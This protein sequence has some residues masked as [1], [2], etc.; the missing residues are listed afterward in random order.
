MGDAWVPLTS[1]T[2]LLHPQL[3]FPTVGFATMTAAPAATDSATTVG[4][5]ANMVSATRDQIASTAALVRPDR[6]VH[7]CL[8][9]HL[10]Y[11]THK[12]RLFGLG[13]RSHIRIFP[14]VKN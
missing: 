11:M 7:L 14:G 12:A 3:P 2:L 1:S 9:C 6:I 8:V 13:R 10:L 5:A 4:L